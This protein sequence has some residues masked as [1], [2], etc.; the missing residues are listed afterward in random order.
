[1]VEAGEAESE[2]LAQDNTMKRTIHSEVT[3]MPD[4]RPT[5]QDNRDLAGSLVPV[6]NC[7][8][9]ANGASR[10]EGCKE[11]NDLRVCF[12]E[13]GQLTLHLKFQ[14]SV[15]RRLL[16]SVF[17]RQYVNA[18]PRPGTKSPVLNSNRPL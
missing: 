16:N 9:A 12:L 10:R 15:S 4:K 11:K 17:G 13:S 1:M 5:Y 2:L 8:R 7:F 14:A 6:R 3:H 18:A